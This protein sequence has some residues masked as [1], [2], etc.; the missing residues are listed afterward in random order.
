MA[1]TGVDREAEGA[2]PHQT[3]F[4]MAKT[5]IENFE[6]QVPSKEDAQAFIDGVFEATVKNST[7]TPEVADFFEVRT[8]KYDDFDYVQNKRSLIN[9]LN[10]RGGSDSFV[11]SDIERIKKRNP[12]GDI[13]ISLLSNIGMT[14]DYDEVYSLFNNCK[15]K[16]VH[17]GIYFEPKFMA[18][19]R[20]FA[21][22]VFLP[23]LTECLI[24][25]CNSRERRSG[26][27]SFNEY[28][29]TKSWTWSHH[30]WTEDP[31]AVASDYVSDP[32]DFTKKY[33]L[34]FA[35]EDG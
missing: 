27:G 16:S 6:A 33:V 23:R 29:G 21:E 7:L 5:A 8:I 22:I 13:R 12:L 14:D 30:A 9:L 18:L 15:L 28:D 32:Y 10:R 34:T 24:L 3:A 20:I 2:E 4:V 1:S 11:E 26:W 25:T 31:S 17:V 19:N 35:Q